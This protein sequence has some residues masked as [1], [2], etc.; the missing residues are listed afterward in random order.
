MGVSD[1]AIDPTNPD[2]IYIATGD[3]DNGSGTETQK[4]WEYLSQLTEEIPLTKQV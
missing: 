4:V 1:I 3:G 2:I